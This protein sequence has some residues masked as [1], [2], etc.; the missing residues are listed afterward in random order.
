MYP[1]IEIRMCDREALE[2]TQRVLGTKITRSPH[3]KKRLCPPHLYPPDGR[4]IWRIGVTGG[5][6]KQIVQRLSSLLT[7]EYL[8]KWQGHLKK[9]P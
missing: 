4:G 9:C 3:R 8:R 2:P 6:A 5:K 7:K 1:R